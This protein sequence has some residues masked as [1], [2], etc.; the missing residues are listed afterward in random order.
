MRKDLALMMQEHEKNLF[1]E[2]VVALDPQT[3]IA[4]KTPPEKRTVTQSQLATLAS[5]QIDRRKTKL[6]RRLKPEQRTIYD[7]TVRPM[8]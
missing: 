2:I 7:K 4:L 3:Q 1:E 5:K 6:Y 8:P